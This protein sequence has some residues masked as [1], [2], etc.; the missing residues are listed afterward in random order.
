MANTSSPFF[1]EV[2]HN[3][4]VSSCYI[5]WSLF[6]KFKLALELL[7]CKTCFSSRVCSMKLGNDVINFYFFLT[8]LS[9]L[10]LNSCDSFNLHSVHPCA[11]SLATHLKLNHFDILFY[12]MEEVDIKKIQ[13]FGFHIFFSTNVPFVL[14]FYNSCF[15]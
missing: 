10:C 1:L 7:F 3:N 12:N 6:F 13:F 15:S 11:W 4:Y 8:K 9:S 14:T 2:Q 5:R